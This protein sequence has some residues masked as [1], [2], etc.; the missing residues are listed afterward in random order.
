[1]QAEKQDKHRA[2]S[3][4]LWDQE[5]KI[6]ILEARNGVERRLHHALAERLGY[7]SY[8]MQC[9]AFRAVELF[10]CDNCRKSYYE[11]DLVPSMVTE[12]SADDKSFQ[13]PRCMKKGGFVELCNGEWIDD[14]DSCIRV[15]AF[16]FNAVMMGKRLPAFDK[17]HSKRRKRHVKRCR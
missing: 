17:H 3:G 10:K 11:N 12:Y 1:M 8:T 14:E 15:K 13:C 4:V 6:L 5:K 2:P 7:E 16:K 9:K